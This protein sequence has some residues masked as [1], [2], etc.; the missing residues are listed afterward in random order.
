MRRQVDAHRVR[1]ALSGGDLHD[2]PALPAHEPSRVRPPHDAASASRSAR[3]S[4]V[5][6]RGLLVT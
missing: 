6:G 4:I 1:E 2:L 5:S 3:S